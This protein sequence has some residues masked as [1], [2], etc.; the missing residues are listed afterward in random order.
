LQNLRQ[1]KYNKLHSQTQLQTQLTQES[2]AVE[3]TKLHDA[4]CFCPV[5]M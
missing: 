1:A 3:G 4:V 5:S 2:S